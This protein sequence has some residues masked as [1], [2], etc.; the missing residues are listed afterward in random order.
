MADDAFSE[1]IRRESLRWW[2]AHAA[3]GLWRTPDGAF[4]AADT[5][6]RPIPESSE[7]LDIASGTERLTRYQWSAGLTEVLVP[8]NLLRCRSVVELGYSSD[9]N[10]L[11]IRCVAAWSGPDWCEAVCQ[12]L[13]DERVWP[14]TW[15]DDL[16][17]I[18]SDRTDRHI[19]WPLFFND[20]DGLLATLFELPED[21]QLDALEEA[22]ADGPPFEAWPVEIQC[23]YNDG[24]K[25]PGPDEHDVLTDIAADPLTFA[26]TPQDDGL[27]G[28]PSGTC[29]EE[30]LAAPSADIPEAFKD[31]TKSPIG[32]LV[33]SGKALAEAVLNRSTARRRDLV[34]RH[35][36]GAVFVRKMSER[37][38]EV[39]FTSHA[40]LQAAESRMPVTTN[41]DHAN[42]QANDHND[43]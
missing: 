35:T 25:M 38:L 6:W 2:L 11:T 10:P 23:A 39:Y 8:L 13:M 4:N 32:P 3:S 28:K 14:D 27:L 42:S 37:R 40:D 9:K 22:C 33:G 26:P 43:H 30:Q 20:S 1:G 34:Q 7:L 16:Q 17:L 19:A 29:Q 15:P 24:R 31:N 21:K 41:N 12:K 36:A 18:A 5:Q